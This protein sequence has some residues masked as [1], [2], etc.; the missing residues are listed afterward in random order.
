MTA[1]TPIFF[2]QRNGY[3]PL[4]HWSDCGFGHR[5]SK[6]WRLHVGS[7][8]LY[9]EVEHQCVIIVPGQDRH[10]QRLS[11]K[12]RSQQKKPW[13]GRRHLKK[14]HC[15]SVEV[16]ELEAGLWMTYL[17]AVSLHCWSNCRGQLLEA[18]RNRDSVNDAVKKVVPNLCWWLPPLL[19]MQQ[20]RWELKHDSS[21]QRSTR[22]NGNIAFM[23]TPARWFGVNGSLFILV[24]ETMHKRVWRNSKPWPP[25]CKRRFKLSVLFLE[26]QCLITKWLHRCM[27][28][29]HALVPSRTLLYAFDGIWF[30]WNGASRKENRCLIPSM[31]GIWS[32][33]NIEGLPNDVP[34]LQ[35]H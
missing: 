23:S 21:V 35:S 14:V 31:V 16:Y 18:T 26:G 25:D 15:P 4:S 7:I 6:V 8:S 34:Q 22:V 11:L 30:L 28:Q 17:E 1:W 20:Y 27:R 19:A 3:R 9:T 5:T 24:H 12:A 13:L 29:G 33:K 10:C 2:Q 32:S